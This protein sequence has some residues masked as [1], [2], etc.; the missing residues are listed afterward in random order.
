MTTYLTGPPF[1]CGEIEAEAPFEFR[2]GEDPAIISF[3]PAARALVIMMVAQPYDPAATADYQGHPLPCGEIGYPDADTFSVIGGLT[4]VR[5]ATES[6]TT[7]PSHTPA[8]TAVPHGLDEPFNLGAILFDGIHPTGQGGKAGTGEL[9]V[10]DP[11]GELDAWINYGWDGRTIE[12]WRGVKDTDPAGWERVARLTCDRMLHDFER[13]TLKL[14]DLQHRL[15]STAFPTERYGGGGEYDGDANVAGRV[16]PAS[17]GRV[18]NVEPVL[19]N[20]GDLIYQWHFRAAQSVDAVRDG[21]SP[22]ALDADYSTYAALVAASLLAGEYATCN[23]LGLIRV[24]SAPTFGLRLDGKGDAFGAYVETRATIA[25]RLVTT[26]GAATFDEDSLDIPSFARVETAQPAAV[27]FHINE[28][29]ETL[30][31]ILDKFMAGCAGTWTVTPAGVLRIDQDEAPAAYADFTMLFPTD[32]TGGQPVADDAP[33]PRA[34]TRIGYQRNWAPQRPADLGG[35]ATAAEQR[36]YGDAWRFA[37]SGEDAIAAHPGAQ[38][39]FIDG[40]Y[41]EEAAARAEAIRQQAIYG[42]QRRRWRLPA[43]VDPFAP[44]IAATAAIEGV[45]RLGWG[46]TKHLRVVGIEA[47]ASAEQTTIHLRD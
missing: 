38:P 5:I 35:A 27:G 2:A 10:N 34:S 36:L 43:N 28:Q 11:N 12:L 20:S 29:G 46:A 6:F 21:A 23:A 8:D 37:S 19:I 30:G 15:Y 9:I 47:S 26:I 42:V 16:R 39:A 45:N 44:V 1:P 25:R 13:K 4:E 14:R 7:Q 31:S 17:F 3:R 41:A 22:L 18:F 24:E 33:P 40:Y 32:F